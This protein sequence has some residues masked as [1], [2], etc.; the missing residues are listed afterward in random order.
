M[1][2]SSSLYQSLISY[3]IQEHDRTLKTYI[4]RSSHSMSQIRDPL[5]YNISGSRIL[6]SRRTTYWN[7]LT[8]SPLGEPLIV[9]SLFRYRQHIARHSISLN[10]CVARQTLIQCCCNLE[11]TFG[12]EGADSLPKALIPFFIEGIDSHP[13]RGSKTC[14][15]HSLSCGLILAPICSRN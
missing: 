10:L 12:L 7:S 2:A 6:L 1:A 13:P 11:S 15:I 8:S 3:D 5:K 9:T 4:S 14:Q